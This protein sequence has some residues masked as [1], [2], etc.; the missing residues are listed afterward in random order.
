M[1]KTAAVLFYVLAVFL[2]LLF[3][4]HLAALLLSAISWIAENDYLSL[5]KRLATTFVLG[6][7]SYRSFLAG[8]RRFLRPGGDVG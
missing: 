5:L 2:G 1:R 4:I 8:K 3:L 6:F 7:F